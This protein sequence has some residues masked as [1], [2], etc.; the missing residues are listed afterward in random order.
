M[1]RISSVT[2]SHGGIQLSLLLLRVGLGIMMLVHGW[3]KLLH[4]AKMAPEFYDPFHL[5]GY[6]SLGLVVF[7]EVC[8]A[9]MLVIGLYSRGFVIPLIIEMMIV[10]FMVHSLDG[11]SRQELPIHF[12]LGFLVILILGPGKIS[13]DG[14]RSR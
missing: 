13:L 7:A 2:Y 1:A 8:C 14:M 3:P 10:I 11:F 6:L 9:F 5:S 12:L 4:Y